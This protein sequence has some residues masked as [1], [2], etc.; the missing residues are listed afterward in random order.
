MMPQS[1]RGGSALQAAVGRFE[2][3]T[4]VAAAVVV[5]L[6]IFLVTRVVSCA[7]HHDSASA[8]STGQAATALVGK[9]SG[10]A[11]SS[12]S[13]TF[14]LDSVDFA[15]VADAESPAMFTFATSSETGEAAEAPTLFAKSEASI[16]A[17][18]DSFAQDDASVGFIAL[19][20]ETGKGVA[21]NIDE[22]FY[23]ASSYKALYAAYV[24]QE[25]VEGGIYSL[26]FP[27]SSWQQT[28]SGFYQSGS[29]TIR[30]A[31]N[32]SIVWS[33][34]ASFGS[35]R[36][37]FDGSEYDAWLSRLGVSEG[38]EETDEGGWFPSYSAR[39]AAQLWLSVYRYL[40]TN[41]ETA[42]WL[43]SLLE[44]TETSFLRDA[45]EDAGYEGAVVRSKAG[46]CADP[47]PDYNSVC[48]G[49]VVS[50]EGADYLICV[51]TNAAD[52]NAARANYEALATAV[53]EACR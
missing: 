31:I 6:A 17:A 23:G 8:T 38:V 34:N 28:S 33:D 41:T 16:K 53:F 1:L 26:G 51:M 45:L 2:P 19:N 48:E 36:T 14:S 27:I 7:T 9:V 3:R 10:T 11:F 13:E 37:A 25:L 24:C 39:A 5:L 12:I 43:G 32:D 49:G 4:L 47:N 20:C 50:Y 22:V 44:E 46:W 29:E 21:Y 18:L 35:L 30:D 52:S 42:A 40:E 15:A